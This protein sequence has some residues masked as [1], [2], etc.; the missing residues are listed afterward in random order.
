MDCLQHHWSHLHEAAEGK[1][2]PI[3][4][5]LP[6]QKEQAA[7]HTLAQLCSVSAFV[8]G[9]RHMELQ[10]PMTLLWLQRSHLTVC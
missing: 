9:K 2:S 5:P 1:R 10:L 3:W 6:F 7:L 4:S 8:N